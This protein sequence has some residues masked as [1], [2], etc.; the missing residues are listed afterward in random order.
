MNA[1]PKYST[2]P[3]FTGGEELEMPVVEVQEDDSGVYAPA[4][5]PWKE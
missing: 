5:A 2:T 4:A 3:I 1:N